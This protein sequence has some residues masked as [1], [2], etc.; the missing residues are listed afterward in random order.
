MTYI[1]SEARQRLLD[2]VAEAVDQMAAALAALGD[3]YEQLDVQR[4]DALEESIFRPVQLAYGR[5]KRAHSDF[6]ARHGLPRR[7][8]VAAAPGTPGRPPRE[9]LQ[10]ALDALGEV[11]LVLTELQDSMLPVEVGDPELRTALADVRSALA[12]A[13]ERVGELLRLLGR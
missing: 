8:F 6:A 12:A 1:A 7:T 11:E 10:R 4:A 2:T 5:A 3:A 13:A 9:P